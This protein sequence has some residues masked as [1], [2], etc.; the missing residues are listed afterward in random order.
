MRRGLSRRIAP[1][2]WLFQYASEAERR[3]LKIIIAAAG[4]AAHLPGMLAAK[5]L[6]PVLAVPVPATCLQGLDSLLSIVQMPKGVPVAHAGD[7]QAGSRQRSVAGGGDSCGQRPCI[8]QPAARLA[9]ERA[10]S[11]VLE[12]GAAG[13]S[14]ILPGS[15]IGILGGGQLGRMTAMAARSLGYRVQVMDPDPSCPAR[16]VVDAC[17][18]GVGTMPKRPPTWPAAAMSSPWKSSRF[19]IASLEAAA[20]TLP[21]CGPGRR[22]GHGPGPY[23]AKELACGI[24][25]SRW[26][27]TGRCGRSRPTC[28]AALNVL[29][30]RLFVRVPAAATTAG[31][32]SSSMPAAVPAQARPGGRWD[33]QPC[34]AEQAISTRNGNFR[35]GGAEPQRR[36]SRLPCGDQSS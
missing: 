14:A 24:R 1:R 6:V 20:A 19:R 31:A 13:L 30:P 10:R 9:R 8:G 3:G 11:E 21:R 16:F 2:I 25:V 29:G 23:Y 5:T 34:V 7:R 36:S 4:G 32:R 35:D 22:S 27:L 26:D 28:A 12:D 33:E 17:F 18:V 15:T